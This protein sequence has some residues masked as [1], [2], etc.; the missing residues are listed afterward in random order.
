MDSELILRVLNVEILF[1]LT[2]H[3]LALTFSKRK[4]ESQTAIDT[5]IL[6]K[7]FPRQKAFLHN[8]FIF[9]IA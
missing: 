2:L 6:Q 4:K 1:T 5:E 8:P 7:R 9:S 3:G